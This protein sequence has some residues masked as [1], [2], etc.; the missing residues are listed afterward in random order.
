MWYHSMIPAAVVLQAWWRARGAG[1]GRRASWRSSGA[2]PSPAS[3]WWSPYTR[4]CRRSQPASAIYRLQ[5]LT[6]FIAIPGEPS[7]SGV[8][9]DWYKSA[10]LYLTTLWYAGAVTTSSLH[11]T[12][13]SCRLTFQVENK[14]I[15]HLY[16]ARLVRG[17]V[18]HSRRRDNRRLDHD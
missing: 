12:I 17:E 9:H 8:K 14:F 15:I 10:N 1:T 6:I 4:T 18:Q 16:P 7:V 5:M 13:L 2:S 11:C 3:T